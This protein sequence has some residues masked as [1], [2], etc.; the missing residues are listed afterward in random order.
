MVNSLVDIYVLT[1]II[2]SRE[3]YCSLFVA[4][5]KVSFDYLGYLSRTIIKCMKVANKHVV[6]AVMYS[7]L[8]HRDHVW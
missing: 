2:V 7:V 1:R 6:S 5:E 3:R 8:A 4:K